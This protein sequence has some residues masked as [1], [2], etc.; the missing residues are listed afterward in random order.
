[1]P[2]KTVKKVSVP[3]KQKLAAI[4]DDEDA[5]DNSRPARGILQTLPVELFNM[6]RLM[7]YSFC[8][9]LEAKN[10]YSCM[11]F[12]FA[13]S[14]ILV[15]CCAYLGLVDGPTTFYSPVHVTRFGSIRVG[16]FCCRIW[17]VCRRENTRRLFG[18]TSV[19][20]V[21]DFFPLLSSSKFVEM[22]SDAQV[23]CVGVWA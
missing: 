11:L 3:K 19:T 6:V 18:T 8:K 5:E 13:R 16:K 9:T 17:R 14:S 4:Q 20:C 12:R 7:L 21:V 23:F 15:L 1:M 2:K 10:L 22:N